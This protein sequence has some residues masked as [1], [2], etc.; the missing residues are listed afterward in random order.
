MIDFFTPCC[1]ARA[2]WS[3]TSWSAFHTA[4]TTIG[5]PPDSGWTWA[6]SI[7][8][9]VIVI[10][11]LL[12]PLFVKQIKASRGMQLIQPE[13]K[14][15]QE[16]YK[17]KTDQASRQAMTQETMA[18]YREHGDEP[19]SPPACRSCCS[20]R[21]SSPCSGCS[22][23]SRQRQDDRPARRDARAAGGPRRRSSVR[24]CPTPSCTRTATSR[25]DPDRRPHHPHVGD[26]VHDAAP[27]DDEEHAGV[28]AGQP[29]RAAAEDPAL[30]PSR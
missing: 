14:K 5:M 17:G 9:L 13:M 4:L 10:R 21:S 15:I 6:L 23:A 29:V 16:K 20:R 24:R 11:I 8:G 18:L 30:R 1:A 12:I 25:P 22:T 7:V 2:T 28:R 26:D 3:R 27:A 19:A